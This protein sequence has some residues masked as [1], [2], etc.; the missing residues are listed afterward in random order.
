MTTY[1]LAI[2]QEVFTNDIGETTHAIVFK[3]RTRR[4]VKMHA[5]QLIPYLE[6]KSE[7][8][9]PNFKKVNAE[10]SPEEDDKPIRPQRQAAILS[11]IK[12][13]DILSLQNQ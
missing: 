12:T 9:P 13:R 7:D 8:L 2:V 1:P 4:L 5:S 6:V 11:Q 10:C 3:G